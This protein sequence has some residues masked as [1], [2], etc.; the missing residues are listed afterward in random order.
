[1]RANAHLWETSSWTK[2]HTP[3]ARWKSTPR[4][5]QYI[6]GAYGVF[7]R[8]DFLIRFFT[9]WRARG[10][11]LC[12]YCTRNG[13]IGFIFDRQLNGEFISHPVDC[14][15]M[16]RASAVVAHLFAQLDNDLIE[17]AGG[18]VIIVTPHL[19]EQAIAR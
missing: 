7:L 16:L 14:E 1:M 8:G 6:I 18:A 11:S 17:R 19:A 10:L 4:D 13:I 5:T 9:D 3:F 15:Q 2:S 12:E